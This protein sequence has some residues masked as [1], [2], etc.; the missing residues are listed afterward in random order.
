MYE[1]STQP[2]R[3]RQRSTVAKS[4]QALTVSRKRNADVRATVVTVLESSI[5]RSI[6]DATAECFDTVHVGSVSDAMRVVR[7]RSASALLLSPAITRQQP[8]QDIAR[9]INK[10]P[11]VTPVAIVGA[12]DEVPTTE[13]LDLGACG[14]RQLFDLSGRDGWDQLRGI[15]DHTGGDTSARILSS[16]LPML[17]DAT[18]ETRHFFAGLVRSAPSTTTVRK[19]AKVFSMSP[20]TLMSRFF[21]AKLPPPKTYLAMTRLLYA[22]SFFESTSL[23]IADVANGLEFSSPQSFGRHVRLML[24]LTAGEFR[25]EFCLSSAL[26]HFAD[27]L[28]V[29]YHKTFKSLRP[30]SPAYLRAMNGIPNEGLLRST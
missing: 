13:L 9:L 8:L 1:Y 26:K 10:L 17:E 3:R 14:V 24:G 16:L 4:S 25:R 23:S 6:D 29:P 12:V 30:I 27:R 18:D 15:L 20:S 11:G 2:R 22:A 28:I 21:R 19:L 5:R 7:E